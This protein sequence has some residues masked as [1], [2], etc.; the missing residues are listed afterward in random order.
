MSNLIDASE[1]ENKEFAVASISDVTIYIDNTANT[2]AN[3]TATE[4]YF[5]TQLNS[6]TPGAFT[7]ARAFFLWADQTIKIVSMNGKEFTDPITVTINKGISENFDYPLLR[8]MKIRTTVADT[9]VKLR[10]K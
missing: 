1:G 6:V 4:K 10:V 3:D 5:D 2:S 7:R 9:N 8:Q